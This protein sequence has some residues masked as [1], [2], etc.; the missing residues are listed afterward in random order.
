MSYTRQALLTGV[1]YFLTIRL[2]DPHSDL[3]LRRIDLL[4]RAMRET[5]NRHPFRIDAITVLPATLHMLCTLPPGKRASPRRIAMLK[6]RFSRGC[7]MSENRSSGQIKRGEKGIWGRH[8]WQHMIHDADDF[9]RH[10]DL[11]YFS[12]VHAGLCATP[13]EWVHTSL[14]RDVRAGIRLPFGL[15]NSTQAKPIAQRPTTRL[16][17]ETKQIAG[18]VP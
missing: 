15:H 10:R 18:V 14:H 16:P 17:D 12:P 1:T 7:P 2:A 9:M 5:L 3:L 4:R 13:Q 11:I 6:S 8:H